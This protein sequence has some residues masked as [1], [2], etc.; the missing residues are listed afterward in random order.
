VVKTDFR[1]Y[2]GVFKVGRLDTNH[3]MVTMEKQH[4][5]LLSTYV[6]FNITHLEH[7][8]VTPGGKHI[9]LVE[10]SSRH[11]LPEFNTIMVALKFTVKDVIFIGNSTEFLSIPEGAGIPIRNM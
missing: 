5:P 7:H 1:E 9:Y 2:G 10:N 6:P 4:I 3:Y 11:L 8:V